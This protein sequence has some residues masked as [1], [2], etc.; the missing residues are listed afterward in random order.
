M[1]APPGFVLFWGLLLLG[2][3]PYY[4]PADACA[5]RFLLVFAAMA[6]AKRGVE[7]F[8][9][10]DEDEYRAYCGEGP[11]DRVAPDE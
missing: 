10:V 9:R 6:L 3:A 11:G 7:L 2:R 8:E 4:A 1:L 5:L